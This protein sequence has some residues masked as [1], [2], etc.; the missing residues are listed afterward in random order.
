MCDHP[1]SDFITDTI[2]GLSARPK[3]LFSKY[4]Y[5]ANGSRIF[6]NIMNMHEY[7]L[8]DCEYEIF[9]VQ[10]ENIL[11]E[12]FTREKEIDIIELG[13]GDGLKTKVLLNHFLEKK[14]QFKYIP[15]DI[16][17]KAIEELVSELEENFPDLNV[18]EKIGDYFKVISDLSQYDKTRKIILFLGSN[19]GNFTFDQSQ[20]FLSHLADVMDKNDKLFI[21]FDLKKDPYIILNAYNDPH[22]HT[23]DF[24]L[25]L[26]RRINQELDANFL[27]NRFLH[28]E[29]YDPVSGTAKS[30]LVSKQKQNI[31][32]ARADKTVVFDKWEPI[33]I[34]MSQKYD[35]QMI[36]N[37]AAESGF[38]IVNN[39][40]DSR[41]YFVNS[42]WQLKT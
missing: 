1:G 7:Y 11:T 4:L 37:L 20:Q 35:L 30:Y 36:D 3:Y 38:E 13:A 10:K 23:R 19:I 8:T 12:F 28:Y 27:L 41:D 40:F 33:Y 39:F 24:N 42:V 22:G 29:T 18:E 25:N 14:K 2:K 32:L 16:S 21:G 31:T 26:L 6:Q 15:I 5:D 9:Q 17:H 34:E